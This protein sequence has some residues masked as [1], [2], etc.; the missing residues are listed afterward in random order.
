MGK[1]TTWKMLLLNK[2][3]TTYKPT[4]FVFFSLKEYLVCIYKHTYIH[5]CIEN[6][7]NNAKVC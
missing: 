4:A 3:K 7:R 1:I 6:V 2:S 5:I